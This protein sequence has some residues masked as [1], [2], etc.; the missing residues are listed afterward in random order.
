M[1][2][3][4]LVVRLGL[5]EAGRLAAGTR[6]SETFSLPWYFLIANNL[7][8]GVIITSWIGKPTFQSSH[9]L[10]ISPSVQ[11]PPEKRKS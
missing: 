4:S 8:Q 7:V 11:C 9:L 5:G 1:C 2:S 10:S 3:G 6:G